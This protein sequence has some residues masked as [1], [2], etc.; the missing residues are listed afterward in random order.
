MQSSERIR[1]L[2][3]PVFG[4]VAFVRTS[5]RRK[6]EDHFALLVKNLG[7]L[8]DVPSEIIAAFCQEGGELTQWAS[9][10][11]LH[12]GNHKQRASMIWGGKRPPPDKSIRGFVSC[13]H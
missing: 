10:S 7:N 6:R 4:A 9:C 1:E 2:P 5:K 13:G 8:Q 11:L 12:V 3:L